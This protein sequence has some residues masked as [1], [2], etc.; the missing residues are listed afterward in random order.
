MKLHADTFQ[1]GGQAVIE[2]VVMRGRRELAIAVRRPDSCIILKEET[3]DP[4]TERHSWLRLPVLRGFVSLAETLVMGVRALNYSA[5]QAAEAEGEEISA[6]ELAL[7]I[8]FSL[9]L[10]IL[11]FVVLP[12]AAVHWIRTAVPG[13][14]AQNVVEGVLRMGI[15][16]GYVVA[17]SRMRDIQR[18][19]EYH[20]AEHK[21]IHALEAGEELTVEKARAYSTLHPRCGTSFLLVVMVASIVI[22]SALGTGELWWR[23]SSRIVLLPLVAGV[24]Y[25]I[26]KWSCR[27]QHRWWGKTIMA[28]GLW[29]QKLTTREPD[30]Q[31]LEV[32]LAA[33]RRVIA[34]ESTR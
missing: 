29:L 34:M 17:I 16:F 4:V 31:Q 25:E 24:G 22:F 33:L 8:A 30:D 5:S 7:T 6:T 21:S 28:P 1:Y 11:L 18:V 26:I 20:G 23:I 9:G 15:F 3:L 14:L 12:T 10:A 27:H 13:V 2:G 32:A 19:F